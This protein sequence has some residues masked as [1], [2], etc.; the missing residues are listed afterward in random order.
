MVA[1]GKQLETSLSV[2]ES[3]G[4]FFPVTFEAP[5]VATPS[6]STTSASTN[7][8]SGREVSRSQVA[9][10]VRLVL[11]SSSKIDYQKLRDD[12]QLTTEFGFDHLDRMDM[13]MALEKAFNL[14]IPLNNHCDDS[15]HFDEHFASPH[16]IVDFISWR[17]GIPTNSVTD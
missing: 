12:S 7:R 6:I 5:P 16:S 4:L 3:A 14:T 1:T 15:V 13:A 11:C 8:S 2:S 10:I 9:E 17:L